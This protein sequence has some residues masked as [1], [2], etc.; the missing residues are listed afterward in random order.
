M[1]PPVSTRWWRRHQKYWRSPSPLSFMKSLCTSN[2]PCATDSGKK[3][4]ISTVDCR[5]DSPIG[6]RTPAPEGPGRA[7]RRVLPALSGGHHL[8]DLDGVQ[9]GALAEVVVADEQREAVRHRLV[10]PDPSHV[11]RV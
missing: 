7:S 2:R 10:G 3:S 9:R 4:R 8:G 1:S 6:R 5:E 11:R